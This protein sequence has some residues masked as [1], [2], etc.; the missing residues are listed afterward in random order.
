MRF[1]DEVGIAVECSL[2]EPQLA[3]RPGAISTGKRPSQLECRATSTTPKWIAFG[4]P[5]A[6]KLARSLNTS[7]FVGTNQTGKQITSGLPVLGRNHE[8]HQMAPDGQILS[9]CNHLISPATRLLLWRVFLV[10]TG[11]FPGRDSHLFDG[12]SSAIEH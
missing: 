2:I 11:C 5:I 6:R 7:A 4:S 10:S 1:E 3:H 12:L 9:E 8:T